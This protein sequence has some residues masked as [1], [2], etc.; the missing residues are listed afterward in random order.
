MR[1]F[2]IAALGLFGL[3]AAAPAQPGDPVE[4]FLGETAFDEVQVSPDGR[5]VAFLSR[6][7]DFARDREEIAIWVAD[8]ERGG[9]PVRLTP[10]AGGYSVLRWSPDGRSLAFLAV[11]AP[12][13]PAQLHLADFS[14]GVPRRLT[15]PARFEDGIFLYDW[16]PDGSG[17]VFAATAPPDEAE[18]TAQKKLRDFYGDVRR[19]P[20]PPVP[21]TGL[22]KGRL[23][24]AG[25]EVD[26][27]GTAPFEAVGL[28][29]L[30]PDGGWLALTGFALSERA[31]TSELVLLP[32]GPQAQ[33]ARST[34]NLA[35]EENLAW[36]GQD[37]FVAAM[38]EEKN[39]RFSVTEGHLFRMGSG[40]RLV[41]VAPD[42]PGYIQQIAPLADGSLL[43]STSV[44]TRMRISRVEPATGK[45]RQLHEHRGWI[46]NF[47]ASR[48]GGKIAFV[49][50][51]ARRFPE[52]Y[53]ADGPDGIGKARPL[54]QSNAALSRGPLPEIE[55]VS[56][57]NGE[58]DTVEGVLFWPPG[59]KGEKNL[60]LVVD[61][62]GGPF[63]V[64]R[65]EAVGLGGAYTS[66]PA[67][68]ASRGFLVLNAN[69]RGSA[70]RGD[71]F[72]RAVQDGHCSR[73]ATDVV[74]GA[75]SLVSR[76]W[77]DRSRLGVVGYSYGG[78]VA[79]C[80][81][82]RSDLFRAVCS[83]A[84]RWND[85]SYVTGGPRGL[86]WA[87]IFYKGKLPW[88]AFEEYWEESPVSRTGRVKTPTLAVYGGVDRVTPSQAEAMYRALSFADAPVELLIFPGEGHLFRK[89]SHKLTKI[90]AEISWLEHY[91]LG[92]PRTEL[93]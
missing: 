26:S 10:E 59:R 29:D 67:L 39:G 79:N 84:G 88:E 31:D 80:V 30:S 45:V 47:S 41:P 61:L 19:L 73:P 28:L 75:L 8:L 18:R 32:I 82:A 77:A 36:A 53:I 7:N 86:A 25:L 65:T 87:E 33:G 89:P 11:E 2:S 9:E 3:A 55:T 46:F 68:L 20:G 83:G 43:V 85:I 23:T 81:L 71:E 66:Y 60:P 6:T 57:D 49:A 13:A 64:A 34:Q 58:G 92:K 12:E 17:M 37:L 90:R 15:D 1:S 56:W 54:T 76:G 69:Y 78:V 50:S 42:L 22:Y 16:L 44:S 52:V 14:G 4:E 21:K 51:D 62:H 38:G 63:S 93:P 70:G 24:P 35:W 40:D 27:L 48:D 72:T 5:R 91:L 74:T